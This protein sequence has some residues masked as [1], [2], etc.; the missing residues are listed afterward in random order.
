MLRT[1]KLRRRELRQARGTQ[2]RLSRL[3]ELRAHPHAQRLRC[4]MIAN[5]PP[6]NSRLP[7]CRELLAN[8][9]GQAGVRCQPWSQARIPVAC[10]F[11]SE[12]GCQGNGCG[13]R[14]SGCRVTEKPQLQVGRRIPRRCARLEPDA[15]VRI[16]E[17]GAAEVPRASR[18]T[19][20]PQP[21]EYGDRNAWRSVSTRPARSS[22]RAF[23]IGI[24]GGPVVRWLAKREGAC[25][26]HLAIRVLDHR[27]IVS[28]LRVIR[29][30]GDRGSRRSRDPTTPATPRPDRRGLSPAGGT[31]GMPH[32]VCA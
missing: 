10:K 12:L 15:G 26:R 17:Q 22:R 29:G 19:R 31:S 27:S 25:D 2:R 6:P 11:G 24:T 21:P 7:A 23:Q 14:M 1:R 8:G 20:A 18:R 16:G 4:G 30:A 5:E 32:P 3:G 28:G 13:D 9:P